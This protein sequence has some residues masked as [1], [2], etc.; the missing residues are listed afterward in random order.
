MIYL[1]KVDNL[2][3][4]GAWEEW[5]M[6]TQVSNVDMISPRKL[7]RISAVSEEK[8][9]TPMANIWNWMKGIPKRLD[10]GDK[11][12]YQF[13]QASQ[14]YNNVPPCSSLAIED[15]KTRLLLGDGETNKATGLLRPGFSAWVMMGKS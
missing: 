8:S 11:L 4:K 5:Q 12:N 1:R 3:S 6:L 15:I 10:L 14:N 7:W 9:N 13:E 2:I